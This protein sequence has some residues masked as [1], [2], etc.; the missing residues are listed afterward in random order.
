MDKPIAA[1]RW[2]PGQIALVAGLGIA[3]LALISLTVANSG[4]TR[5]SVD[6]QRL[7]VSQVRRGE[8]EEYVPIDGRV[9]PS[10]S[11]FLDLAEGGIV[12]E[13][14][15]ESGNP[16]KQGELILRFAN[17][18]AQ[19]ENIET[20][21]RLL[22]NLN[23]LRNSKISLTTSSLVL[24]E[25]L[26]DV[27]YNIE[28]LQARY[29]RAEQ[30]M[31]S[32]QPPLSRQEFESLRD[33][34]AYQRSKRKLLDERIRKE[35]ELE[36]QQ[37][38][39]IELSIARVNRNLDVLARIAESLA[40]RAPVDGQ[41]SS[42]S[43]EV[44]Q[45]FQRG[46]RIGQIDQ[47]DSFKVQ[48]DVDQYYI[49]KVALGQTGKFEMDGRRYRLQ[50]SK[51]YPEVAK[52]VFQV[53]MLFVGDVPPGIRRGQRLQIDLSLSESRVTNIIEKGGFY[54]HSNGRWAYRVAEDGRSAR[55]TN[56]VFGRE[57]PQSVEVIDGL[58]VG[59]WVITSS[60][61]GLNDVDEL[62]LGDDVINSTGSGPHRD[63]SR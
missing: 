33:Q 56:V 14:A 41:L 5:L 9:Q 12:E 6:S 54:R 24:Q 31:K 15:V 7:S 43:A 37:V 32:E 62:K 40:V 8:L 42:L 28:D 18:A 58:E 45:S 61:E 25:Q 63:K 1:R 27:Q 3:S 52:D 48:A 55:R 53:D 13:I 46:A 20:E 51:V 26:L 17:N 19:K 60:Y 30:L 4:K 34:L 29:S 22:E 35:S 2:R 23:Q 50:V 44:G 57:N 10:T 49:S 59:D 36:R 11:V 38:A 47:L 21:T 39:Q 16:V